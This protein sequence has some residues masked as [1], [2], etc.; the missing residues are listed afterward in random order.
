MNMQLVGHLVDF[1]SLVLTNQFR[2][3][4]FC[5]SFFIIFYFLMYLNVNLAHTLQLIQLHQ[6]HTLNLEHHSLAPMHE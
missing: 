6:N 4:V 2:G 5:I 1:N 3:G